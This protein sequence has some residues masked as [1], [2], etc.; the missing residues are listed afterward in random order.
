M[1]AVA[2]L[3]LAMAV[4]APAPEICV[5]LAAPVDGPVV[6][7]FAP[8]GRWAGHW[9]VDFGADPGTPVRA[10]GAGVVSFDGTVAGNRTVTIDHGGGLKT[11]YSYLEIASAGPGRVM[12][13]SVIARSGTAHGSEALHFS[14]RVDGVYIDPMSVLGCIPVDLTNALWLLP[15]PEG[16]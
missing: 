6:A 11:S 10:A 12:A 3:V 9:G 13:G 16:R 5:G 14:V 8:I 2:C 15:P 1:R 7:G 4:L